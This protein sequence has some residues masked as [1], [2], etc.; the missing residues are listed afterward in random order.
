MEHDAPSDRKSSFADPSEFSPTAG[1]VLTGQAPLPRSPTPFT[2]LDRR[3][4]QLWRISGLLGC[5]IVAL[6]A[7][8]ALIFAS[9]ALLGNAILAFVPW[10]GVL[11]IGCLWSLWYPARAYRAWGYR[12]EERVL[13]IRSGVWFRVVRF[14]PL[15]RLQHVDLH[16][17]P[18]ERAH[19]LASLTLHTAGTREASLGIP[20][21]ADADAE[22]LRDQ[23]AAAGGDDAV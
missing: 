9:H 13:E 7:L 6:P 10:S 17:G 15:S 8:V 5:T 18:L 3:V 12:V 22:G 20:G 23:L 2:A 21:L 4:I 16:R 19:G 14:L 1:E 11:L